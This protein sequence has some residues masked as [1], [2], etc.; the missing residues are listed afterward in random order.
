MAPA[1]PHCLSAQG[2]ARRPELLPDAELIV[3][4]PFYRA[5]NADRAEAAD[6][7]RAI[8]AVVARQPDV[9]SLSLAGPPNA[10]LARVLETV[11]ARGIPVVA[12]AGNGGAKSKPL[13]PAAYDTTIAVTAVTAN[14]NIF[15]RASR[16]DH[17]DFAAPGVDIAVAD[18]KNGLTKR[19]GTSFAVPFVTASLA[20]LRAQ[21]PARMIDDIVG[22]LAASA[23]D[24]GEPG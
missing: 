15:R 4:T 16:G 3:A 12:A 7:I 8:D 14:L 17:V 19:S 6:I 1:S 11:R 23:K 5:G 24:L 10:A 21:Q 20:V 18:G 9:L 13:Y 2:K 22:E